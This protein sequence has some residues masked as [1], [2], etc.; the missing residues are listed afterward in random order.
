MGEEKK[1]ETLGNFIRR[2]RAE[3]GLT[4]RELARRIKVSP[5][6]VQKVE[7][8]N[9]RPGEEKLLKISEVLD[10]QS[11][12]LLKLAGK[13]STVSRDAILQKPV[14]LGELL[15][16]AKDLSADEIWELIHH[17]KEIQDRHNQRMQPACGKSG[18][19]YAD[20]DAWI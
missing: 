4:L 19:P 7:T 16:T 1:S 18:S 11:E 20:G 13:I 14:E 2:R 12:E 10:C 8:R 9:W 17:A 15:R 5:A 3:R 6:F